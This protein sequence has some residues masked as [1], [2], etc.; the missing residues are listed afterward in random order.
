MTIALGALRQSIADAL[1]AID[2]LTFFPRRLPSTQSAITP[3]AWIES[4]D[5]EPVTFS[6]TGHDLTFNI[7]FVVTGSDDEG[8]VELIDSWLDSNVLSDALD[9]V[10]AIER[11][12]D[13]GGSVQLDREYI[14][15][16]IVLAV[17]A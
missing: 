5:L 11:Y 10:G 17:V 2:G 9:T 7:T 13:V 8:A 14:G 16:G 6:D 1:S 15:F 4:I 12:V 3:F